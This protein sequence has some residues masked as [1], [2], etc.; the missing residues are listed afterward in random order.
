MRGQGRLAARRSQARHGLGEACL[1]LYDDMPL[2]EANFFA[3][4]VSIQQR[5][6]GNLSEA[7]QPVAR[8]ARPQED[9][10]QDHGEVDGTPA[11]SQGLLFIVILGPAAIKVMA[12]Q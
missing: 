8:A 6:G 7:R 3:I 1:K 5:A 4:V 12:I 2:P 9:E 11:P 10:G